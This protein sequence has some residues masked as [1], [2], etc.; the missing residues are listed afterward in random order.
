[1]TTTP[2]ELFL[3]QSELRDKWQAV[4]KADW[5]AE[6]LVYLRAHIVSSRTMTPDYLRGVTAVCDELTTLGDAIEPDRHS[7][8]SLLYHAMDD[9]TRTRTTEAK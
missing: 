4:A 7:P 8:Q 5:F 2:K 1:M 6:V 3:K 9:L